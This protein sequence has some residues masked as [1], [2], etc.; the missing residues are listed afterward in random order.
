IREV[1][2]QYGQNLKNVIYVNGAKGVEKNSHKLPFEIA[3]EIIGKNLDYYTLIGPS[4]ASEIRDAQPTLVNLGYAKDRNTNIVRNLFQTDYFRVKSTN[5]VKS[6]ELASAFKNV[7]AIACGMTYGL[8]YETNT[9]V[10]LIVLAIE[11][12]YALSKKMRYT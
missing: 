12:F 10:K 5:S 2:T 6:L 9:R 7:Y 1:L 4:F 11:E 3:T 8:G